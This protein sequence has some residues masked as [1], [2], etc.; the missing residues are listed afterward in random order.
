LDVLQP[1]GFVSSSFS[2]ATPTI[3]DESTLSTGPRYPAVTKD[4][5]LLLV[6]HTA[7]PLRFIPKPIK[8]LH[9]PITYFVVGLIAGC[10]YTWCFQSPFYYFGMAFCVKWYRARYVFKIPVWDRQ[11]NWN[12]VIT[13]KSQEK[14]LRALTCKNCGTTLFIA[15]TREFFFEGTT[16]IGGLGCFHCGAK[17]KDNFIMDRDR[18]V[19]DVGDMDDYFEYERPLD[20]VS[21]AERRKLLQ[22]AAGDEEKANQIL[23]ERTGGVTADA[24][25]NLSTANGSTST[26]DA[27]NVSSPPLEFIDAQVDHD[28]DVDVVADANGSARQEEEV[29]KKKKKKK[30]MKKAATLMEQ[31]TP[32]PPALAYTSANDDDLSAL[33]M[34]AW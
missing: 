20:F 3:V 25:A 14:T 18:I 16:G 1:A 24:A 27:P 8:K 33:D 9:D 15:K 12:N 2:S 28:G 17:G 34:D 11:P 10:R 31:P 4:D 7:G 30:K 19:A 6:V 26:A 32:E 23:V 5:S 29:P 22:E 21:R 13:D